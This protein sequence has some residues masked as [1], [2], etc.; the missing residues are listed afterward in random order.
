M[1]RRTKPK[2]AD[3]QYILRWW[4][5][6]QE[7]A[8]SRAIT[9]YAWHFPM[10]VADEIVAVTRA[11][12]LERWR[13][14]DPSCR[15]REWRGWHSAL[16]RFCNTRALQAGLFD[17]APLPE[18]RTCLRCQAVFS[19]YDVSWGAVRRLG[20]IGQWSYCRSCCQECLYENDLNDDWCAAA[21]AEHYLRELA[22]LY[23]AVPPQNLFDQ[24]NF[25]LGFDD[26]TRTQILNLGAGRPTVAKIQEIYGSWLHALI[27][28]EVLED[29]THRTSRGT[30]TIAADGHVCLSLAEKTIDDW[31]TSYG[32]E[33]TREPQ[34]P[35]SNYRADFRVG[36]T[37]IE[38]FGL[39]GDPEY[40]RKTREKKAL[41]RRHKVD[42]IAIYPKDIAAWGR[43]QNR[44]AER[45]G[46]NLSTTFRRPVLR[47]PLMKRAVVRLPS[48]P[49]PRPAGP[50]AGWYP[51]PGRRG[52]SRYWDGRFWTTQIRDPRDR[53]RADTPFEDGASRPVKGTDVH[54]ES[55]DRVVERISE[56]GLDRDDPEGALRQWYQ[57]MDAEEN[58]SHR[59][60]IPGSELY[61]GV[62][63]A[64]YHSAA[65]YFQERRNRPA[66][67]AVLER[68][69]AQRHAPGVGPPQMLARRDAIRKRGWHPD[70]IAAKMLPDY[71]PPRVLRL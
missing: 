30:R 43:T 42:L 6:I 9:E 34:Y 38:Y 25:L 4:G 8:L 11:E 50:A 18:T 10:F 32:I 27:A 31:L 37:F 44:V 68:F 19:T 7:A 21:D 3:N 59:E 41:A 54:G 17:R 46:I 71:P 57:C 22:D 14:G 33:H 51:D 61:E 64:P 36:D 5:S 16:T 58:N 55:A 13:A 40:D 70:P 26:N 49:P 12:D 29:G 47:R 1:A 67:L 63:P 39:T 45:L 53:L 24:A 48:P 15:E 66:E 65:S 60:V 62:A 56:S 20:G 2:Y 69:A 35:D 23:Q 28:A 52:A